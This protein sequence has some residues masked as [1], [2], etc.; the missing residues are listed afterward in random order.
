[1][2][3]IAYEVTESALEIAP[4]ENKAPLPIILDD[5]CEVLAHPHLFP[6]G[7]FGYTHKRNIPLSPTKYFNQRLLNYSQKFA[8]DS[9]YIFFAQSV[10]QHL[11]LNNSINI[12]MKK[13][14]M[15]GLTAGTLSKNTRTEYRVFL[16]AMTLSTS[17]T[18]L[19]D[20]Q[21]IGNDFSCRYLQ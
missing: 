10:L 1:M 18:R 13:V 2:P 17:L 3:D 8:S 4:G 19:T 12:A 14:K 6:K 16:Q 9:D 7:K 21:L 11:N 5:N 15:D 20:L